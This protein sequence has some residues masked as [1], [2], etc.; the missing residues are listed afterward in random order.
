M[1]ARP[2]GR[3]LPDGI[4]AFKLQGSLFFASVGKLDALSEPNGREAPQA[5][6]LDLHYVMNMDTTAMDALASLQRSLA[7][8]GAALLICCAQA[9]PISLMKR[10]GF[11][12][13]LGKENLLP[14]LEAGLARAAALVAAQRPPQ[15]AGMAETG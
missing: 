13:R 9:Q 11:Y 4:A 1:S 2:D 3:A 7:D 12:D 8:R 5:M 15:E 6:L 10:S 14:D